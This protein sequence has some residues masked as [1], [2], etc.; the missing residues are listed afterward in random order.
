MQATNEDKALEILRL[1]FSGRLDK[2]NSK[3][4]KQVAD[5]IGRK[6]SDI[7]TG[8]NT[9][10]HLDQVAALATVDKTPEQLEAELWMQKRRSLRATTKRLLL[11][12][13]LADGLST[14]SIERIATAM[15][16]ILAEAVNELDGKV[17]YVMVTK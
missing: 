17:E 15:P 6:Y 16:H 5:I 10:S 12:S 7:S 13:K 1:I 11:L 3:A 9:M 8:E 4:V 14:E 2:E